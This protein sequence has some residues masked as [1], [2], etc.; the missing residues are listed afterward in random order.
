MN[1]IVFGDLPDFKVSKVEYPKL[2][3]VLRGME[4]NLNKVIKHERRN[5]K[6]VESDHP[7]L[8][9][10]T[11]AGHSLDADLRFHYLAALDLND[12]W[13][14]ASN[15]TTASKTAS[16]LLGEFLGGGD[17]EFLVSSVTR[18][19]TSKFNSGSYVDWENLTPV[20]VIASNYHDSYPWLPGEAAEDGNQWSLITI[21]LPMLSIMYWEWVKF[22]KKENRADTRSSF[23]RNYVLANAIKSH[24]RAK[25]LKRM[26]RLTEGLDVD[27]VR[28]SSEVAT[29]DYEGRFKK[30]Q[31]KMLKDNSMRDL[32]WIEL[33]K[34]T[35]LDAEEDLT[36]F[37]DNIE[38]AE[39]SQNRWALALSQVHLWKFLLLNDKTDGVNQEFRAKL[40]RFL[41]EMERDRGVNG[42]RN[43]SAVNLV[44]DE[45]ERIL[46]LCKER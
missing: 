22:M 31:Y 1:N 37:L 39:T 35:K 36:Y 25:T 2:D 17:V 11:H 8:E 34:N 42:L 32:N 44:K 14:A 19:P 23:L 13:C 10:L 4:D 20:K 43:Y 33:L 27:H 9:M 38:S 16:P 30:E 6:V 45:F 46:N 12:K 26:V 15:I 3:Y 5:S 41:F 29:V 7:L 28:S 40:K 18:I 21:D 24:Q